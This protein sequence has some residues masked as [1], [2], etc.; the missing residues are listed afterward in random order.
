MEI[1]ARALEAPFRQIV[2]NRGIVSPAAALAG[3]TSSDGCHVYD[4]LQ[5]SVR[6]VTEAGLFDPAGVLRTALETAVSGAMLALTTGVVVLH[7]RPKQS[8]EP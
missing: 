2:L 7:R 3:I 5:D 1:L 4:V 8:F 6:P